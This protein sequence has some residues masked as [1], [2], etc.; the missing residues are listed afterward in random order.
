[1]YLVTPRQIHV[2][3]KKK[4]YTLSITV[5][6]EYTDFYTKLKRSHT[7]PSLHAGGKR[8]N[9]SAMCYESNGNDGIK[10]KRGT[11]ITI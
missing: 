8:R 5:V 9:T 7:A 2:P 6:G 11:E 3:K 10:M 4:K 1:M